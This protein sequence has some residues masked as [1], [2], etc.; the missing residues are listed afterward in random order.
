[1]C[2]FIE[3]FTF[4]F[5]LALCNLRPFRNCEILPKE[6]ICGKVSCIISQVGDFSADKELWLFRL[7][8]LKLA[9]LAGQK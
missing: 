9:A 5:Y 2:L 8:T 7:T 6:H 3:T 1:M 4:G